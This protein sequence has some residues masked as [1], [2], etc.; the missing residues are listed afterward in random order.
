MQSRDVFIIGST[1][2][3]SG[4]NVLINQT[5][6]VDD[7][8]QVLWERSE[9]SV[10]DSGAV[11]LGGGFNPLPPTDRSKVRCYTNPT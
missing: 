11:A 7:G 6:R 8:R 10:K 1:I 5:E 9:Q 4:Q 2:L 3:G